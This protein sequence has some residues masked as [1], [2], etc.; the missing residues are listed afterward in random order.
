LGNLFSIRNACGKVGLKSEIT[1]V[2]DGILKSDAVILPGVGSFSNAMST[3]IKLDLVSVLRDVVLSSKPFMGI[4]LG[5]HLLMSESYEFGHHKGLGLV[6]GTVL[7]FD[8]NTG[9]SGKRF[10]VPHVGWNKIYTVK[11]ESHEN[12]W[13]NSVLCGIDDGSFMY[14]VH[15]YMTKPENEDVQLSVTNYGDIEFCSSFQYGNLFA[16]QFHPERSGPQG[17]RIY[18]N[19]AKMISGNFKDE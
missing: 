2:K 12:K 17:L 13:N 16:C 9:S 18:D 3:L 1:N 11:N 10:K 5:M 6:N 14:F 15:S 19:F 4:C 7:R 8:G